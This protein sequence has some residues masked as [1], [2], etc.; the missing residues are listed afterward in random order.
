MEPLVIVLVVLFIIAF[1]IIG[2]YILSKYNSF[3]KLR[4]TVEQSKSGIDVYC[5]QRF[6]LIPNLVTTVKTYMKFEEKVLKELTELRTQYLNSKDIKVG[7][8]LNNQ[9]NT[10]LVTAEN[11][12]ELKA[13]EQFLNLQQN[14][15]KMENQL[16]AARRIYNIAVTDYNTAIAQA[17]GNVIA[18]MF[19]FKEAPLF[20]I[21]DQAAKENVEVKL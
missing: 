4:K 14:L 8:H 12:P 19:G 5:Q 18:G 16:Q 3:I 7:E 17:P 6:D 11:Y 13:S 9:L 1:L 20:E 15:T 10:V 2:L 21:I